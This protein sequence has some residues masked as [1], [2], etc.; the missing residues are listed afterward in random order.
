MK[1]T[2]K[3]VLSVNEINFCD[4]GIQVSLPKH[5][6]D[7]GIQ[8]S[9]L[10][11]EYESLIKKID[12]LECLN[13][14]LL[15]ENNLLKKKL[16]NKYNN[17]QE[18]VKTVVEIAKRERTALYDDVVKL[19]NNLVVEFIKTLTHN[20]NEDHYEGEKLF[21][22][23]IA[24]D[25]IYG[26]RHLKYV[27]SINLLLLAIK[28]S[29]AKSKTI[30][31]IDS[32]IINA[33]GFTKFINWQETLADSS[34]PFPN[35]IFHMVTSFVLFNFN[36]TNQIQKFENS[37]L[38]QNL[39]ILQIEELFGLTP[40]MQVLLDCQLHD[41]LSPIITELY[42]EKN[43][44]INVIDDLITNQS[45]KTKNQK[46]CHEC[47]KKDIENSKCKCPQYHSKLPTLA[48]TQQ[49]K[50]QPI[51]DKKEKDSIKP[52][53]FRPYQ[54]NANNIKISDILVPDPL[55]INPNSVNNVCKVFDHIQN[56]SGV[57]NG[58]QRWIVVVCDG[59]PYH[60]VQ[61]FK[62]E[63][64][65]IILLSGPLHKEMNM[66]K[67]FVEL[68]CFL[69]WERNQKNELYKLK[70]EQIFWYLQAIINFRTGVRYNQPLLKSVARR[71]FAP[72][73]SARRHPIYQAIEVA[74]KEQLMR[75]HPEIHQIIECNSA[76]A[77]SGRSNQH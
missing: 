24:I 45:A 74:N 6:C 56:I 64:S 66:L 8:V 48:E 28:Y 1:K 53:T 13:Q 29:I 17:Q 39:N 37:W 5:F 26:I 23:A 76:I 40:E 52:L 47:G 20:E 72:I 65:K 55:P 60:Y 62:S 57:N 19:I 58:N 14:Q 50:E 70:Y 15:L 22:C 4:F 51:S 43:E 2:K 41:Y 71:M 31:D 68:N 44:E 61:K 18:R 59:L 27:S 3:K 42:I 12:E 34:E 7:F 73:W 67:A 75:L 25:N 16:N 9:L 63:Y 32:H 36:P 54:P 49:E 77:W 10:N 21:K 46:E 33:G 69:D 30:V 38:H 11:P 35:V